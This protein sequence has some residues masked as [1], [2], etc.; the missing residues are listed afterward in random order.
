LQPTHTNLQLTPKIQFA[1]PGTHLVILEVTDID[2]DTIGYRGNLEDLATNHS[3]KS[4]SRVTYTDANTDDEDMIESNY[5]HPSTTSSVRSREVLVTTGYTAFFHAT[6]TTESG[7]G[8]DGALANRNVHSTFGSGSDCCVL[9]CPAQQN[10]QTKGKFRQCQK[11]NN[12]VKAHV[13]ILT[14]EGKRHFDRI[15]EKDNTFELM[16]DGEFD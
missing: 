2:V 9:E 4:A 7:K 10:R 16:S 6:K 3:T 11:L 1:K 8:K 14:R 13:L 12:S 5:I 15:K